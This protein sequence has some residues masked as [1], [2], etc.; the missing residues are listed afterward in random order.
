MTEEQGVPLRCIVLVVACNVGFFGSAA[1][2]TEVNV[3]ET[4]VWL[5]LVFWLVIVLVPT[6]Q[7]V[8][9]WSG[10][11]EEWRL[12]LRDKRRSLARGSTITQ[13]STSTSAE[14]RIELGSMYV[15][16]DSSTIIMNGDHC[17]GNTVENPTSTS[18]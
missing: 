11:S 4:G 3:D 17:R 7:M 6:A 13:S 1:L 14:G 16:R 15:D 8:V 10:K 5:A 12:L 2:M 9:L 18:E